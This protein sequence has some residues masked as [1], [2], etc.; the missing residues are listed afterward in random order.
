MYPV[1]PCRL[2]GGIDGVG[3]VRIDEV[4]VWAQVGR[5]DVQWLRKVPHK[6]ANH[7]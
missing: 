3:D 2:S 7:E 4:A 6:M 5:R 1:S